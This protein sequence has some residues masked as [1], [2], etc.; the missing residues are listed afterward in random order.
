V[1]L[2][3]VLEPS[4]IRDGN[5]ACASNFCRGFEPQNHVC[6]KLDC[7]I[8]VLMPV[9]MLCNG[10]PDRVY[11]LHRVSKTNTVIVPM[12]QSCLTG[13]GEMPTR[14]PLFNQSITTSRPKPRLACASD[15]CRGFAIVTKNVCF[16]ANPSHLDRLIL[17]QSGLIVSE[18]VIIN[19]LDNPTGDATTSWVEGTLDP[20]VAEFHVWLL[21]HQVSI[22]FW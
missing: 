10:Q 1:Q 2:L 6:K 9:K 15:F 13:G 18:F 17:R 21:G 8:S 12:L 11:Q 14:M 19:A 22:H 20:E 4:F 16:T 3:Q 5:N 7:T